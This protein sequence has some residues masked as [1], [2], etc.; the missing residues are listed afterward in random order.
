MTTE[1]LR[2]LLEE[3]VSDVEA[4]DLSA[5]AW[6]RADGVRRRRRIAV[7]GTAAAAVLVV[8][9]GVAVLDDRP[10]ATNVPTGRPTSS[11]HADDGPPGTGSP[12]RRARRS[13]GDFRGAPFWWAPAAE[14]DAR[15]PVLAVPGLPDQLSMADEDPVTTPP[16]R[17]DAVFATGKQRYRLLSNDRLL[18]VDLSDRLGPVADAGGNALSPLTS[19]SLSP[20][21][22]R[23]LFVQPE[24]L[25]V[26]DLPTNTWESF[27]MSVEE[28]EQAAWSIDGHL[29]VEQYSGRPDPWER[30]DHQASSIV[31]GPVGEG[32][33][34]DW[35]E[36]TGAPATGE[37]V[38]VANPDFLAVGTP[39]APEL[40]AFGMGRNKLCC[41]PMAW[42]S[43][44]F[45]LFGASSSDGAYRVLAWR[46]GTPDLYRV[47]E[48]TDIVRPG[49][50]A[51]WAEDA[52]R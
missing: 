43:H 24:G 19:D 14:E 49:F 36:G 29:G 38:E 41:A 32:A 11:A 20:D 33:E 31:A 51:S 15:L 6:A 39:A 42:F 16:D 7:V 18:S 1:R 12:R 45:L 35:M 52:F 46:I 10:S 28:A 48:Y 13:P 47:S 30:G 23:V 22:T 27:P 17:V 2:D 21:G 4:D 3:R 26:W 8:A 9:G 25:E 34:L 50:V 40:L 5:R 44:E 37:P